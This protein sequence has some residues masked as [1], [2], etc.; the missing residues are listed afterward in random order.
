MLLLD[1]V[2]NI[3]LEKV[4]SATASD[5]TLGAYVRKVPRGQGWR[6]QARG[7]RG[8]VGVQAR[9]S[10]STP[11]RAYFPDV[12]DGFPCH[13]DVQLTSGE[14]L[15]LQ[16]VSKYVSKFSVAERRGFRR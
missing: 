3:E 9:S 5:G 16:Y 13:Q 7:A 14:V 8:A 11:R 2:A 6:Q 1:N 12:V 15:L 4:I 10:C